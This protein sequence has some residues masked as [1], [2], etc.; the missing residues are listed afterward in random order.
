[1]QVLLPRP[2]M[3]LGIPVR[4]PRSAPQGSVPVAEQKGSRLLSGHMQVRLLPG[5]PKDSVRPGRVRDSAPL[6]EGGSAGATP[7]WGTPSPSS[8]WIRIPAYEAGECRFESY[9]GCQ[10]R[11]SGPKGKMMSRQTLLERPA[12][13]LNRAWTPI[14][15][16]SVREAIS[17]VAKGSAVIIE[18]ETYETH[19]LRTWNDV[20]RAKERLEHEMIHSTRLALV[21]PE[22]ILLKVYPGVGER[23]VIFSRKNIFKRDRYTC[24]YCGAQPGPDS[25]TI[26]HVVPRSKG[27]VS[28]WSNCVLACVDCNRRKSDR[29]PEQVGMRLRSVPRKPAWT[30]LAHVPPRERRESWGQF[31]SRAY[32]EIELEP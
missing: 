8:N 14:Q 15:V 25:L 2:R 18:P 12:L 31:L 16:T 19:D 7:A 11:C 24:Q 30:T 6:S 22:V 13:V 4:R 3:G 17:L 26:E 28:T 10:D 23:S 9:R 1:M 20:S 27:G 32:W 21:P 5:I 29:T